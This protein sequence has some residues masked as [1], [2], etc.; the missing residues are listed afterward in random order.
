MGL[1]AHLVAGADIWLNVPRPPL[2]ASGTSGMKAAMNGGLNLSVLDGWWEEGFNGDNG[3]GI[4]SGGDDH[5]Q[6]DERDADALYG[7]LEHEVV[8][9]FYD[10]DEQGVPTALVR[11]IKASLMSVGPQFSA[12]RMVNDYLERYAQVLGRDA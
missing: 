1:A 3:W 10:R 12:T 5:W 9:T 4:D 2:E 11:R 6:Q 7:I 8:P